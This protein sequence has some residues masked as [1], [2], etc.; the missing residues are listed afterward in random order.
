LDTVI[1]GDLAIVTNDK[2]RNTLRK[3]PKYREPKLCTNIPYGVLTKCYYFVCES[4]SYDGN[5]GLIL[6]DV[7]TNDNLLDILF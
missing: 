3:G 7:Q 2:L 1:T 5:S 4:E 6:A